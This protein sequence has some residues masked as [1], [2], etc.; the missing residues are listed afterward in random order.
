MLKVLEPTKMV[1]TILCEEEQ[2]TVS[3]IHPLK[4]MLLTFLEVREA[5]ATLVKSV[6]L[7]I[8]S[9]LRER[10]NFLHGSDLP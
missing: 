1:T 9:D 7:A 8:S 3:M 5:D 10:Y 2:P 4:E 6:K